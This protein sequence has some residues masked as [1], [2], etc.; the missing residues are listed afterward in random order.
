MGV[1]EDNL[2]KS[3]PYIGNGSTSSLGLLPL[4]F[5]GLGRRNSKSQAP[6][7]LSVCTL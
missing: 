6:G 7:L 4:H 5:L 2:Y 1:S 3:V